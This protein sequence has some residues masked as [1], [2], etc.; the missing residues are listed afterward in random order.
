MEP[1]VWTA[2]HPISES[3]VVIKAQHINEIRSAINNILENM[4]AQGVFNISHIKSFRT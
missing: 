1:I 3:N 2:P 4:P